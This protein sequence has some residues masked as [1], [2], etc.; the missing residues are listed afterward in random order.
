M[1]VQC[2]VRFPDRVIIWLRVLVMF[3][4]RVRVR[5]QDAPAGEP[6]AVQLSPQGLN[7][8]HNGG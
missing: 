4:V 1:R 3:L 5:S 6:T 2:R 7:G 8:G